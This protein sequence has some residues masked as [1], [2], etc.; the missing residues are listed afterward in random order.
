MK[1]LVS[2]YD[3][4]FETGRLS[5]YIN[6][7]SIRRFMDAGNVFALS[8]GRSYTSLKLVAEKYNI[9]YD[10]LATCDGSL[11]FDKDGNNLMFN[12]MSSKVIGDLQEL[13]G[14]NLHKKVNFTHEKEYDTFHSDDMRLASIAFFI[15]E[16][17][18]TSKFKRLYQ[19]LKEKHPELDF[20]VYNWYEEYYYMIKPKNVTKSTT[21]GKLGRILQIPKEEIY[22]VGDNTNDIEMIR[23][24]NGFMIGNCEKLEPVALKRYSSVRRLVKDIMNEKALKR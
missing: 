24:Y 3:G 1:L 4:T 20:F 12:T 16:G 11:L 8:S 17:K 6:V 9:P 7:N 5:P 19:E 23:D 13:I 10:Y 15:D 14:L 22:T 21:V 18:I 2:D